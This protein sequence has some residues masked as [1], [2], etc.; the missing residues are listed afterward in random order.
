MRTVN[1]LKYKKAG[2]EFVQELKSRTLE[3]LDNPG[4]SP[5]DQMMLTILLSK[6]LQKI[7]PVKFNKNTTLAVNCIAPVLCN[8]LSVWGERGCKITENE[9]FLL[10]LELG[11]LRQ[12]LWENGKTDVL[13]A[14][15]DADL[16]NFNS[17]LI[18]LLKGITQSST[19]KD[20]IKRSKKLPTT[21]D[22]YEH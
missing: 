13:Q 8:I 1:N 21:N 11:M 6:N 9:K 16:D 5:H 14:W 15:L 3:C 20:M 17:W 12:R 18:P 7:D 19:Y 10:T 2:H 4:I 22:V